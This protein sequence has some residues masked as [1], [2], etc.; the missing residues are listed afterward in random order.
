MLASDDITVMNS[1]P[2]RRAAA[3]LLSIIMACLLGLFVGWYL[4]GHFGR[5]ATDPDDTDGYLFG[6]LVG[7]LLAGCGIIGSLG[8]FWPRAAKNI[9][10]KVVPD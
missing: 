6:L 5:P 1:L 8:K 4:W 7:C 3:V 9:V 2:R 10:T